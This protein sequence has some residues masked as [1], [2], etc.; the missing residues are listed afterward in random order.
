MPNTKSTW[1]PLGPL[2]KHDT[3]P[4]YHS[5]IPLVELVL[6][7]LLKER[8]V[9]IMTFGIHEMYVYPSSHDFRT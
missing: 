2:T 8:C 1:V 3:S 4:M 6:W 5:S 9:T 7:A